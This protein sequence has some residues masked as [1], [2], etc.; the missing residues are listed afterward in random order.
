MK[1]LQLL[2]VFLAVSLA[3]QGFAQTVIV[4]DTFDSAP[5]WTSGPLGNSDSSNA[6]FQRTADP[7]NSGNLVGQ[8]SIP[9]GSTVGVTA[10]QPPSVSDLYDRQLSVGQFADPPTAS[11]SGSWSASL[12]VYV[13]YNLI[14][15][16]S[17][18]NNPPP[19]QMLEITYGA[20]VS[21][22]SNSSY[23]PMLTL[24]TGYNHNDFSA[25]TG[26]DMISPIDP[27]L[28]GSVAG[29]TGFALNSWHTL[30]IDFQTSTN[31]LGYWIDGTEV[32]SFTQPNSI[33]FSYVDGFIG[34]RNFGPSDTANNGGGIPL[35]LYVDDFVVTQTA[36]VPEPGAYALAAGIAG[37]LAVAGAR[38]KRRAR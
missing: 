21:R 30:K 37:A 10:G 12:R 22:G 18:Q 2:T 16:E 36:A 33:P 27:E 6:T 38:M 23:F 34:L 8:L 29:P 19:V 14:V 1:T 5:I 32:A 15:L 11:L 26:W 31:T 35:S 25:V 24:T 9:T 13:P 7:L 3:S 28:A 4:D 20:T 17:L